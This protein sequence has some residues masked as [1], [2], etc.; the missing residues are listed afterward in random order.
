MAAVPRLGVVQLVSLARAE[1]RPGTARW[2]AS[3]G[4]L[5]ESSSPR[6]SRP[7]VLMIPS[8][9]AAQGDAHGSKRSDRR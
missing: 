9:P 1:P 4:V 2:R 8:E 7:G 3:N 5:R 6:R